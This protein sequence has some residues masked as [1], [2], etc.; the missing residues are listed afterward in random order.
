MDT[1]GREVE[2]KQLDGDETVAIWI[3]RTKDRSQLS[4]ANLMENP[5]WTERVWVRSTGSVRVQWKLLRE[6]D[7]S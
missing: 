4:G 7:S 2:S 3:V 5:K 6:G 1:F